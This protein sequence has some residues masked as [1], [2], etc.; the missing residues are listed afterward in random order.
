MSEEKEYVIKAM[1]SYK[2]DNLE[3]ATARFRN[4]SEQELDSQYG[5]SGMTCRQIWDEYKEARAAWQK[6]FDWLNGVPV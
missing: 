3:R 4:L 2:G 1:E 5:Q 6:A